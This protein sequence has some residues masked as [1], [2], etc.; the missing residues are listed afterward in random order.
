V[1]HGEG[2]GAQAGAGRV[3]GEPPDRRADD[4]GRRH[5]GVLAEEVPQDRADAAAAPAKEVEHAAGPS[6]G[7]ATEHRA[8]CGC[9]V[10]QL[11]Q[12]LGHRHRGVQ[13][14]PVALHLAGIGERERR[15]RALGVVEGGPGRTARVEQAELRRIDVQ[16]AQAMPREVELF[17]H[18]RGAEQ[19][20]VAVADVHADAERSDRGRAPAHLSARLQHHD[21]QT[22]AG[23][24]GGADQP[25]VARSDDDRAV[26]HGGQS[27]GRPRDAGAESRRP[28]LRERGRC[29]VGCDRPRRSSPADGRRR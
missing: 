16:V 27:R 14:A 4:D 22:G 3:G 23:E 2:Q 29:A 5:H 10:G 17:H 8:G 26:V 25:V 18:G 28:G 6:L 11:D 7:H 15:E 12:Q 1:L 13:V 21:V 24:V 19:P 9:L 20:V